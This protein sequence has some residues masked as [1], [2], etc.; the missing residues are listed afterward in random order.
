MTANNPSDAAIAWVVNK[1]A[2]DRKQIKVLSI[3]TGNADRPPMTPGRCGTVGWLKNGLSDLIFERSTLNAQRLLGDRFYRLDGKV[4]CALDETTDLENRL[5][6]PAD[7][8]LL[9]G[10]LDFIRGSEH[11]SG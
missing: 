9:T 3:G 4:D 5:I 10:A 2:K 1:G 7:A 6:K 8:L 11:L